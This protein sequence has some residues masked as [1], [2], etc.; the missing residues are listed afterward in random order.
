MLWVR[1]S[2]CKSSYSLE[3]ATWS[4][5]V[6]LKELNFIKTIPLFITPVL[7]GGAVRAGAGVGVWFPAFIVALFVQEASGCAWGES[8]QP[9]HTAPASH[10]ETQQPC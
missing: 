4:R 6:L 3:Q 1:F 8:S 2:A 9:A 7:V 5:E 10:M